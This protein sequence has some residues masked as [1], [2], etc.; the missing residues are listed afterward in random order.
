MRLHSRS[1]WA[2]DLPER[3]TEGVVN[4]AESSDR[5][6]RGR[7]HR[8]PREHRCGDRGRQTATRAR[9]V[10]ACDGGR[11]TVRGLRASEFAGSTYAQPWLVVDA[12]LDA[13]LTDVTSVQFTG[14]PDRPGVTLPLPGRHHR[15]E[16]MV[17]MRR[18]LGCGRGGCHRR[19]CAGGRG[20]E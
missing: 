10:V 5:V 15:W 3:S 6:E 9:Y 7:R 2:G 13:P 1:L 20:G 8:R 17:G 4:I 11:S 18:R 19:G 14:N 16:F 12:K